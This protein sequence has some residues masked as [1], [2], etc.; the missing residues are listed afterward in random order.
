MGAYFEFRGY[1]PIGTLNY[2]VTTTKR[3]KNGSLIIWPGSHARGYIQHIDTESHLG[4]P[5][6]EWNISTGLTIDGN[7]G[8]CIFFHQYCVHAS[9]KNLSIEPRPTF[10]NR[11]IQCYDYPI[12]PLATSVKMRKEFSNS[13]N[14]KNVKKDIGYMARGRRIYHSQ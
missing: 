14:R 3:K 8:D 7:G 2:C 12:M 5:F 10:I 9:K 13:F 6:S 11:Y 4:L 1:G